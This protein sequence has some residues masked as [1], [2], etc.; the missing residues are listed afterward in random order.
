[1]ASCCNFMDGI[2]PAALQFEE[3]DKTEWE[4]EASEH[5]SVMSYY[6]VLSKERSEHTMQPHKMKNN[7]PHKHIWDTTV[8]F[9][10]TCFARKACV[11]RIQTID[12][13]ISKGINLVDKC[14]LCQDGE[15]VQSTSL[16]PVPK[17]ND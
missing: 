11:G 12:K 4:E 17:L 16:Y 3:E 10:V 5:F 15:R 8:P 7:L 2:S 14:I 6:V 13:L 1:M 9:R